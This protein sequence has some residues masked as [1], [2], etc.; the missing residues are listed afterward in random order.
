MVLISQHSDKT[1]ERRHHV[2]FALAW[3]GMCL[4]LGAVSSQLSLV[5]SF[6][7]L[8]LATAGPFGALAP[9]WAIPTETLPR[10]VA[11]SAMGL[12]NAIGCL[13]GYFGPLLVGYL[14]KHTGNFQYAFGLLSVSLLVAA[15]LALFLASARPATL[16]EPARE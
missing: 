1:R 7:F 5:A 8:F 10:H 14:N 15:A 16:P 2:A 6:V 3:G 9:F 13:G 11:G 12:V 4:L